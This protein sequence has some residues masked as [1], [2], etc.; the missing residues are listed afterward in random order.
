M[1]YGNGA[2][3]A[4]R[5]P[6]A[7][8]DFFNGRVAE[9]GTVNREQYSHR[10][11]GRVPRFAPP[12]DFNRAFSVCRDFARDRAEPEP[13]QRVVAVRSDHYQIRAP[14]FGLVQDGYF[15]IAYECSCHHL[16][17]RAGD[18]SKSRHRPCHAL[19]GALFQNP[20]PFLLRARRHGYRTMPSQKSDL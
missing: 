19:D 11:S 1:N 6:W 7:V 16:S 8:G 3:L 5:W 18:L 4:A 12:R 20:L 9:L 10:P 14:S 17:S 2:N 13:F 15:R